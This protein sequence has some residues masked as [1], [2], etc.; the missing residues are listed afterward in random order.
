[1]NH[2]LVTHLVSV[3]KRM[4][5][6]PNTWLF[7]VCSPHCGRASASRRES[8]VVLRDLKRVPLAPQSVQLRTGDRVRI[9]VK[10]GL[11]LRKYHCA[12]ISAFKDYSAASTHLP[13]EFKQPCS[14]GRLGRYS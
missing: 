6:W 3:K 4:P 9:E 1:M 14:D 11:G 2:R 5:S 10:L 7:S 12:Y 8:S 13:L